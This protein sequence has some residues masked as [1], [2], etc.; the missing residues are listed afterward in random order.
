MDVGHASRPSR[1]GGTLCYFLA[2]GPSLGGDAFCYLA[3]RPSPA[4]TIFSMLS[5]LP[6]GTPLFPT[7]SPFVSIHARRTAGNIP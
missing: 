5:S 4:V 3:V 6:A 1:S 7:V 2:E